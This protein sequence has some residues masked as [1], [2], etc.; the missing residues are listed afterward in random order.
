MAMS[1][2]HSHLNI[3]YIPNIANI[4]CI[5]LL[6]NTGGNNSTILARLTLFLTRIT[7]LLLSLS[8]LP[9]PLKIN[10][11]YTEPYIEHINIYIYK[12][13]ISAYMYIHIH[14]Y[15]REVFTQLSVGYYDI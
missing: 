4:A 14:V 10:Y 1:Q 2:R 15:L 7:T 5:Q 3:A 6:P 13:C 11:T 8:S 9:L 12:V